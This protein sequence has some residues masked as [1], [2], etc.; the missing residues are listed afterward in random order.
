MPLCFGIS[1]FL[2]LHRHSKGFIKSASVLGNLSCF[3]YATKTAPLPPGAKRAYVRDKPHM[4]IGTIGHVDHGKTTL[5]AAITKVLANRK[6]ATFRTY[7]EIDS[8][9]EEQRR[10]ITINAATVDYST[11][12]R[13]YAHTDCPGHADYIKNMITGAN[14][15]ECAVLV[16]AATDGTMPQTKEHMLLAKQIGIQNMVVFI[17]KADVADAEML[18]LV[19]LEIREVL[20][21]Y[22]FDGENTP[23]V[24]GSALCALEGRDPEIGEKKV[25]ELLE[26]IDS[27]PMPPRHKDLP[28]YLPIEQCHQITGRGTVATGRVERGVLK[29]NEQVEIMGYN[30]QFKTTATG[31]EMFRQSLDKTEPGDQVGVL[32]RGL[33]R[34]EL[35]RGMIIGV[36]GSLSMHNSIEA[37]VYMLGKNESGREKPFTNNFQIQVFSKSWDCP[38]QFK[39]GE[40]KDM[41]MPGED[42]TIQ[43]HLMKKMV[44]SSGQRFTMRTGGKTL[45][46]G[47]TTKILPDAPEWE[48]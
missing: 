23:I 42:S 45:G 9:P 32:L 4:N 39:L 13:H 8:A 26:R 20:T 34:E 22:G 41:V 24:C 38:A 5:T 33:K 47:V 11:E 6:Q 46:Y 1:R 30:K 2:G 25:Q 35:R 28:F 18:E 44:L 27:I 43:L 40:G 3:N 15:M 7:A 36:P 16:V 14:Q 29:V 48:S 10:G 17:N 21:S 37:Q 19:E 12:N 31:L